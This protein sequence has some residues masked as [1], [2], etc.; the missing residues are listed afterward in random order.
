METKKILAIVVVLILV[1]SAACVALLYMNKGDTNRVISGG[2]AGCLQ[3]Y[4]N[5]NNDYYIN[6]D[7]VSLIEKIISEELDWETDYPFADANCD[8]EVDDDDVAFVKDIINATK[9][10]KAPANMVGYATDRVDGYIET[11][12]VPVTAASF[13][14]SASGIP[15]LNAVGIVDE[16]V[17]CA[18]GTGT[19]NLDPQFTENYRQFLDYGLNDG[20][21]G[22]GNIKPDVT[23]AANYVKD[24]EDPMTLFIYGA[25]SGYDNYGLRESMEGIG[26]KMFQVSDGAANPLE[27]ASCMLALGFIFGTDGNDYIKKSAE[28]ADWLFKFNETFTEITGEISSGSVEQLSAVATSTKNYVSGPASAHTKNLRACGLIPAL[29]D[30]TKYP[31]KSIISY[32]YAVDPWLNSVDVDMI[33]CVSSPIS[34]NWNWLMKDKKTED[35]PNELFLLVKTFETMECYENTIVVPLIYPAV[36]RNM[37]VCEYAYPD[38]FGTPVYKYMQEYF[39]TFYGWDAD[40]LEGVDLYLTP[41][42]MGIEI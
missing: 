14:Y 1:V 5:A 28:L 18:Y 9:T 31:N 36:F 33:V 7:D 37:L 27:Y 15:A 41:E 21:N 19:S 4:G 26:V 39:N 24:Q 12:N 11:I 6:N 20:T 34:E 42:K 8:S 29:E 40:C 32:K 2:A 38:L 30:A 35:I 23:Y 17:A 13:S 3:V 16:F 22:M 25:S 10:N